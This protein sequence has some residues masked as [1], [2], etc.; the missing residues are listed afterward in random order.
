ML[1]RLTRRDLDPLAARVYG[2]D[3]ARDL[4]VSEALTRRLAQGRSA[5]AVF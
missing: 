2:V 1:D 5:I 3:D 4:L